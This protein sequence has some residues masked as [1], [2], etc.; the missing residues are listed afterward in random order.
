MKTVGRSRR[1]FTM[2]DLPISADADTLVSDGKEKEDKALEDLQNN[3]CIHIGM[4]G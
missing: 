1:A 3:A 2:D 4:G